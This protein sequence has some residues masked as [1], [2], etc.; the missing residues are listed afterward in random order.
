M[1]SRTFLILVLTTPITLAGC[2]ARADRSGDIHSFDPLARGKAC[3]A[4][5]QA[6]DPNA[7]PLLVDR[8]EDE[9]EAV[10]ML[11]IGA[12]T[13]L[14]GMTLG[15]QY[16]TPSWKRAKAVRRWRAWIADGMSAIQTHETD[17]TAKQDHDDE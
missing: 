4:M 6:N 2:R 5:G 12:L 17:P 9:D 13:R 15:Y 11:A 8:L 10:R 3:L 16:H 7:I 1:P 14:T